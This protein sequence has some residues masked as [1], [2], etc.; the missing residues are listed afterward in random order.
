[1]K[2]QDEKII[3]FDGNDNRAN[4]TR[5]VNIPKHTKNVQNDGLEPGAQQ[6]LGMTDRNKETEDDVAATVEDKNGKRKR[7]EAAIIK[8]SQESR[9]G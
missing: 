1:M 4:S 8:E 6:E 2:I 3:S 9:I 7:Q 5:T